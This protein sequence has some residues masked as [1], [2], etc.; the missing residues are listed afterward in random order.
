MDG[1]ASALQ[2]VLLGAGDTVFA[3]RCFIPASLTAVGMLL[4]ALRMDGGLVAVWWALALYYSVLLLL[5]A[6]RAMLPGAG[7]PLSLFSKA[8]GA[9]G[10]GVYSSVQQHR[11][12]DKV[13]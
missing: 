1:C 10:G 12:N 6:C 5:F 9:D 7:G 8:Q 2:G 4:L 13:R 11:T 3:S